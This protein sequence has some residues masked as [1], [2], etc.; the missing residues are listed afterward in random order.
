MLVANCDDTALK[1]SGGRVD[2]QTLP[3]DRNQNQ[4]I[5]LGGV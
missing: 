3:S 4:A 5:P 1:I 2:S